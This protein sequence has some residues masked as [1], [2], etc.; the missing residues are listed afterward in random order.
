MSSFY[1]PEIY[2][3]I[4]QSKIIA[5][6]GMFVALVYAMTSLMPV[7]ASSS[8]P[9]NKS[10]IGQT[11]SEKLTDVSPLQSIVQPAS[12]PAKQIGLLQDNHSVQADIADLAAQKQQSIVQE[13]LIK[14]KI[15]VDKRLAE[16]KAAA[17]KA[18]DDAIVRL[19]GQP[20]E[21][22]PWANSSYYSNSP[23]TWGMYKRQCVSY[24]AWKVASSGRVMPYW[25]GRGNASNWDNNA[26]ASGIPVD[27]NPRVG[28]VAVENSGYYGHVMF[29]EEVYQN[30]S[31][32]VSQYNA[33]GAG[34]YS[35]E[36]VSTAGLLFIH[37]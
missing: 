11:K 27:S 32:L 5:Y 20:G 12:V 35:V 18:A 34:N 33:D 17:K 19:K 2:K 13:E 37:F 25:G 26:R 4:H 8:K 24:A 6:T 10:E 21:N 22:Y 31:I 30:G 9:I 14:K 1:L 3:K 16:E 23:D 36:T 7:Y 29:V 28:D 15:A